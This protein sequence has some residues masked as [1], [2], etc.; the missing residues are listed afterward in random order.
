MPCM[1][2]C[3]VPTD[4]DHR[5]SKRREILGLSR[6]GDRI[7]AALTPLLPIY[8]LQFIAPAHPGQGC[9]DIEMEESVEQRR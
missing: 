1:E 8:F 7:P 9:S 4:S 5:P 3:H 6:W 2:S